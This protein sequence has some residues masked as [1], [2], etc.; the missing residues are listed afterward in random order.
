[1]FYSLQYCGI[2]EIFCQF[3][4]FDRFVGVWIQ[5]LIYHLWIN[6]LK[7]KFKGWGACNLRTNLSEILMFLQFNKKA[8]WNSWFVSEEPVYRPF[9][10]M[11]RYNL[12]M[13]IFYYFRSKFN[14]DLHLKTLIKCFTYYNNQIKIKYIPFLWLALTHFQIWR[15]SSNPQKMPWNS[16]KRMVCQYCLHQCLSLYPVR[17]VFNNQLTYAS[18]F[19]IMTGWLVLLKFVW[20]FF[21]LG[22]LLGG[23]ERAQI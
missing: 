3:S 1:M 23:E 2:I 13:Y 12:F 5:G 4:T 9:Y 18:T 17:I 8:Q 20:F 11:I 10:L 16:A 19:V 15:L 6:P 14:R 21:R 22:V 7:W